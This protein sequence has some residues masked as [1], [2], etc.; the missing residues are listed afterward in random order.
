MHSNL[1]TVFTEP[2]PASSVLFYAQYSHFNF[3]M[4][5]VTM[6]RDVPS[7]SLFVS[8]VHKILAKIWLT[9]VKECQ[10]RNVIYRQ[11]CCKRENGCV[12]PSTF[13]T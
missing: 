4:L 6:L 13:R 7:H 8:R 10:G 2:F 12:K 9:L 11:G 5:G 3:A 1:I